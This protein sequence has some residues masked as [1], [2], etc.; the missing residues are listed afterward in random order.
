MTSMLLMDK[1]DYFVREE[2]LNVNSKMLTLEVSAEQ[3][4]LYTHN[5]N[6]IIH[7]ILA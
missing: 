3:F 1:D 5:P 2:T 7:C 6:H 4:D